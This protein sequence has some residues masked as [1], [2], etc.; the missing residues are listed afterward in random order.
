MRFAAAINHDLLLKKMKQNLSVIELF[1]GIGA[2]NKGI[3]MTGLYDVNIVATSDIEKDA[4]VSYAAIHDGLTKEMIE[5]YPT[6]PSEEE[7]K[8]ALMDKNIGFDFKKN[9][10]TIPRLSGFKLKK[11]YL[12][13]KLSNNLGDISKVENL[14]YADLWTYSSPCQDWSC[15]GKQ[16]GGDWT[17]L[18]CGEKYNP[19]E[20]NVKMRY[21]C[22]F[23]GSEKIKSTRSGLLF[24]V[25]RLL[26]TA[27][28]MDML[29]KYLLLEN[30]KNLVGKKFKAQY[31]EWLLRLDELGY[32]TYWKI[33]DAKNYG[34]PQH[35]ERVFA[36][37][38]RKDIDTGKFEFA[39]PYDSGIRLKDVLVD[40]V[41]ERYYIKDTK[42]REFIDNLLES[43]KFLSFLESNS[44]KL[45]V[46]MRGR[47]P[48]NPS[49]RT[50]GVPT[51]Q[52]LE[53]NNQG[54]CNTLTSVQKD[55]LVLETN[56]IDMLGL[57]PVKG[58]EQIRRVYN[59]D[60]IAPTL[61]TMQGGNRQPKIAQMEFNTE[62]FLIYDDYNSRLTNDQENI[63]TLT[64]NIGNITKGNGIKLICIDKS[65][66]HTDIIENANCLIAREDRGISNRQ[67]EGTAVLETPD[68][69][70][71]IDANYAKG[72]TIQQYLDKHR[73]QLVSEGK[74]EFDK[75]TKDFIA[76]YLRIR[77]LIPLETWRLMGFEDSDFDKA[78]AIGLTDSAAYRE[79]GN[80]IVTT[81][82]AQI[83]E[84]LYKA[85]YDETYICTDEKILSNK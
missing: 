68:Y 36:L 37:S 85:Q 79:A 20:M 65:I 80:S 29:P 57:L 64:Q 48:E 18:S 50:V 72:T 67:K 70:Y 77:K 56:Q 8:K 66:N 55:N 5:N 51:V 44:S 54:V 1:S 21:H 30:V 73:R 38:I 47:N 32:N 35:R 4:I 39:K 40:K 74:L 15:A 84:H 25:E 10:S 53:P 13:M 19:L 82:I 33:L 62:N 49:D 63:G 46:A 16:N 42:V 75:E 59:E 31:D 3:N 23:C 43:E 71:C 7:M 22:P 78:L 6:Y 41:D 26:T 58:N 52:R 69:S 14:P 83:A 61:N 12:A 76:Q 28:E 2:Q 17:C 11:Y 60:G 27:K 81:C 45:I 9:T 34:I 24:E